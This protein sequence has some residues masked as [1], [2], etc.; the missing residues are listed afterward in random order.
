VPHSRTPLYDITPFTALDYPEHLAAI[1]WFAGCNMQCRYCYNV[2]IVF[3]R[4]SKKEEEALAFL[5]RCIGLLD[6]V[7]LSGGEATLYPDLPRFCE[8]IKTLGFKIKLDTNGLQTNMLQALVTDKLVD[9]IAL[10]YKAPAYKFSDITKNSHFELFERTLE[11]LIDSSV[12]FEVRT[13]VHTDLLQ[14]DDLNA[15]IR[16][17]LAKGY[18]GSYYI[19]NF[20]AAEKT[21]GNITAPTH[22]FD[23]E[24]ISDAL[25]VIYR[26]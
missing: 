17:L 9:Y 26:N 5:K 15:I 21:I 20:L 11:Y 6:G 10:D 24:K 7:V 18:R 8:K 14:E 23:K 12:D 25:T 3:G 2:D 13:T 19:Q 16:D 22:S 1:L 4:G